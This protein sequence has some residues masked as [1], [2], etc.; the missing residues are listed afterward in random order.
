MPVGKPAPPRPRR[1]DF[2]I[3]ST[4]AVGAKASAFLNASQPPR[5][6]FVACLWL[7]GLSLFLV[8]FLLSLASFLTPCQPI[9]FSWFSCWFSCAPVRT[10]VPDR[11]PP[12]SWQDHRRQRAA[13][14]CALAS[15]CVAR[16]ARC[17][18]SAASEPGSSDH[19]RASS[20]RSLTR[21]GTLPRPGGSSRRACSRRP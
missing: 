13:G 11:R 20:A 9:I 15:A 1:F 3:S 4:M 7:L 19:R 2:L 6:R 16:R 5:E 10:S 18:P 12:S 17:P 8:L 14:G 21:P